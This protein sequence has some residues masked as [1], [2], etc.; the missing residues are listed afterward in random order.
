M[1]SETQG[2]AMTKTG[3]DMM[4]F[5]T[6]EQAQEYCRRRNHGSIK[7]VIVEGPEDGE[8]TVMPSMDAVD[9]GFA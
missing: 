7:T 8:W 6:E 5:R 2:T 3:K 1:S 9:G 4:T